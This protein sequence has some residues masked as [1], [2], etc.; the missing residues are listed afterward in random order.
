MNVIVTL[1]HHKV[2]HCLPRFLS[3]QCSKSNDICMIYQE[4]RT[5]VFVIPL[6][7]GAS[8]IVDY[9]YGCFYFTTIVVMHSVIC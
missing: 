6:V 8:V 3:Q 7:M 1:R 5:T 4:E 2:C 9:V